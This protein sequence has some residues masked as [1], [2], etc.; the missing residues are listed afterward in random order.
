MTT[1][2][3]LWNL[4]SALWEIYKKL[5]ALVPDVEEMQADHPRLVEL[6]IYVDRIEDLHT[7]V[8]LNR[9]AMEEEGL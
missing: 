1:I 5:D 2:D 6:L 8:Q 4:E 9:E 7:Y 3:D